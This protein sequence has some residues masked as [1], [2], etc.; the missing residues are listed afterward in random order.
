MIEIDW[1][2]WAEL[3][4]NFEERNSKLMAIKKWN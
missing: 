4:E 2:L 1:N 3:N